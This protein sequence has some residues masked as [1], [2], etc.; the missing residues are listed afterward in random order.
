MAAVAGGGGGVVDGDVAP[1]QGGEL[2]VGGRL[3]A[4]D[5]GDVVRVLGL[6]QPGDVRL[7]GVQGIEGDESSAQVQRFEQGLEVRGLGEGQGPVMGDGGQQVPA[8]GGPILAK[9]CRPRR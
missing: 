2:P 5:H 8:A 7:D 1:G 4:L 9:P 6:D 3:V